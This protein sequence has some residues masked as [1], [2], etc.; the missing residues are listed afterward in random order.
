MKSGKELLKIDVK[1]AAERIELCIRSAVDEHKTRGILMGLSGGIDSALLAALSVRALGKDMAHVYFLYDKNSEKDSEDK[2]RLV[3]DW[4]GL[5]LNIKSI[6]GSMREK[7]KNAPFFKWI[8]ALPRFAPPVIASLYY[9]VVGETPYITTLRQNEIKKNKF[10]K[11]VYEH[12]MKG[13]EEMFDGP[14]IERRI[15]LEEVAKRENLLLIG[16]GNRSEDLTG[17]FTIKGIDNMPV[18]PIAGLYKTQVQ[19]LAEYLEI[20]AVIQKQESTADVLRGATDSLALGM[21]Y[22]KIDIILYSIEHGFSDEDIMEYGLVENEIKK[23]REINRL[24]AWKR[25][26]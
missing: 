16:A 14:C 26:A 2:A 13:V 8:S 22:D 6:E 21:N 10:R 5:K 1:E 19:Q 12:M 15:V 17:W 24:S 4:L 9:I 11:W 3:A 20:P 7:E 23:V 25:R 18:S